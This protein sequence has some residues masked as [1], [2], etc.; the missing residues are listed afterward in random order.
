MRYALLEPRRDEGRAEREAEHGDDAAGRV[1]REEEHRGFELGARELAVAC[2]G[3]GGETARREKVGRRA[4]AGGEIEKKK[5]GRARGRE[6]L[7]ASRGGV[8]AG[9]RGTR[10]DGLT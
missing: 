3:G 2:G 7:A 5:R 8:P 1:A 4:S 10:A 9:T 6:H